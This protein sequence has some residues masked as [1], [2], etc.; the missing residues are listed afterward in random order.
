[1]QYNNLANKWRPKNFDEIYGQNEALFFLKESIIKKNIHHS[2]LITGSHGIGKT[3]IA[4]IFSKCINCYEGITILPCE[5]CK[6]C[7]EINNGKNI[8]VVELD[9]ASK[10]KVE[11]IRDIIDS[12]KYTPNH[13]RNKIYIIDEAHMLSINSFN[14]L[15]KTLEEPTINTKFILVTTNHNKLPLTIKSRCIQI[16]LKKIPK[17]EII[18]RIKIICK[19]EN[20]K[21]NEKSL[22]SI[23]NFSDG[24]I[25]DSINILEKFIS[26]NEKIINDEKIKKILGLTNRNYILRLLQ[27]ITKNKNKEIIYTI[28]ELN[29]TNIDFEK[30]V[31]QLQIT[32]RKII[33]IKI[34]K[35]RTKI[36]KLYKIIKNTSIKKLKYYYKKTL[37]GNLYIKNSPN[38]KIGFE[39]LIINMTKKW[40][41]KN[42]RIS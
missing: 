35:K 8:D 26:Q 1:M 14:A 42:K 31:T 30:I 32:I 25:R 29:K 21:Y 39:L 9:A 27:L 13:S 15:L 40:N 16:E 20:I 4:R 11:D 41:N 36:K 18:D 34:L 37:L 6:S 7:I 28:N 10:T 33:I 38:Q 24:S 23:I 12:S 3:S 5:N 2:Y 19:F 17:K 22:Q